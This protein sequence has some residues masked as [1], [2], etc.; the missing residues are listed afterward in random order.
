MTCY[1]LEGNRKWLKLVE[2]SNAAF[3][4]SGSPILVGD[5]VI[6][7]YTDLVTLNIK[8]GSEVWRLKLST[9]HGTPLVT[10]IGDV[11]VILTPNGAMVRAE[12]G[13]LLTNRLGHCGANSPILHNG[14]VYYAPGQAMAF[15]L[16]ASIDAVAKLQPIWKKNI[17][18]GGYLFCSPV[19]H[20]G[21][22]YVAND[23]GIF[24]VVDAATGELVYD[25]RLNLGGTVYP[26]ISQAGNRIYVSDDKGT[27]AVIQPGREYK[28]LAR[29]K[30]ET[31]RSSIVFEGK[32]AYIRT[33]KHLYCIGE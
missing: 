23:Q 2:H 14:V 1:D 13:K 22:L 28:E 25:E 24:S 31:F 30:L 9:K 17:K 21:L 27:T 33:A 3:A 18:G 26:S 5:K 7:H 32:R 11:D 29:N 8:D 15:R 10:K 20:D 4:H 6:I 12:D 16:P 19:I